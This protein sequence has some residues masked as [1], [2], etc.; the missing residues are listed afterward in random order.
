MEINNNHI[1]E[2]FLSSE[3]ILLGI[4]NVEEED[5]DIMKLDGKT[6]QL[7][8]ILIKN[9][10]YFYPTKSYVDTQKYGDSL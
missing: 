5:E 1:D 9:V 4:F 8:N 3:I 7:D 6:K 2:N 10:H